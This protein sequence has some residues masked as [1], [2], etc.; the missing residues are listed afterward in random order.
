M[1]PSQVS[2]LMMLLKVRM[3][4]ISSG[5]RLVRCCDATDWQQCRVFLQHQHQAM[6]TALEML[7]NLKELSG[8][9][10][11]ADRQVAMIALMNT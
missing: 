4:I 6:P 7:Y 8:E 3:S 11:R 9:Q 2:L 5:L 1:N 10:N